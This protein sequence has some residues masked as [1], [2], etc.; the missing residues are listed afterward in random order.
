MWPSGFRGKDFLE[1]TNQKK[2][3]PAAAG[4]LKNLL[5]CNHLAKSN[6]IW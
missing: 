2:E 1:L 4:F 5:L 6:E 3:L